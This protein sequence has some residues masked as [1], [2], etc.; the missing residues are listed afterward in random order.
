MIDSATILAL[1]T[2]NEFRIADLLSNGEPMRNKDIA[3]TLKINTQRCG[4]ALNSLVEKKIVTKQVKHGVTLFESA[5]TR[6]ES[7]ETR[8]ESVVS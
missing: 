1:K 5:R 7:C 8:N 3:E 6:N 4:Q 2:K